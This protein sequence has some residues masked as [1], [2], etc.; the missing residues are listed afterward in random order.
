[1]K[2]IVSGKNLRKLFLVAT[3]SMDSA[4]FVATLPVYTSIF[5]DVVLAY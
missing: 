2:V 1:M 5:V 4:V 3:V